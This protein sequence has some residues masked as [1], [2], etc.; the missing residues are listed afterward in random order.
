MTQMSQMAT[1]ES[2]G[3]A[4]EPRAS[5]QAAGDESVVPVQGLS[6]PVA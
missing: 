3:G 5:D 4:D 2:V 6:S 1:D